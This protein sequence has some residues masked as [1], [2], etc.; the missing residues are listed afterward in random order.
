MRLLHNRS[1]L[2]ALIAIGTGIAGCRNPIDSA[3]D[4]ALEGT[5]EGIDGLTIDFSGDEAVVTDFGNSPLGT[6]PGV[7]STG[8]AFIED[9]EC[10][11]NGCT[12]Q[13]V[14]PV[15]VNGLLQ[16]YSH[17]MVIIEQDG[18]NI[19]LMSRAL[20]GGEATFAPSSGNPGGNPGGNNSLDGT[21]SC[22][23]WWAVLKGKGTWNITTVFSGQLGDVTH[24]YSNYTMTFSGTNQVRIQYDYDD[25]HSVDTKDEQSAI[26]FTDN[27]S[28]SVC[29]LYPNGGLGGEVWFPKSYSG[30]KVIFSD[31]SWHNSDNWVLE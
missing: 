25:G 18:N 11:D 31:N 19:R 10:D 4:F 13:I 5:F 7:F 22:A 14:D 23:E 17:E 28:G 12:G 6:N 21:A 8:G 27:F 30:G 9:I 24:N 29:R 15:L 3:L 26:V 16:S 2:L 1:A 20:A